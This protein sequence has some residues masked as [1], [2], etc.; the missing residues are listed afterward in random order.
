MEHVSRFA[1]S[2]FVSARLT[3]LNLRPERGRGRNAVLITTDNV[4][5]DGFRRLRIWLRWRYR[6]VKGA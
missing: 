3:V 6:G 1:G 2:T 5:P 4:D